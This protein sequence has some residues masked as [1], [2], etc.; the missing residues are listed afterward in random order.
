MSKHKASVSCELEELVFKPTDIAQ[1]DVDDNL[2]EL[3]AR[4]WQWRCR[5][6]IQRAIHYSWRFRNRLAAPH[7]LDQGVLEPSSELCDA[8]QELSGTQAIENR[9]RAL[10]SDHKSTT[11][12]LGHL[13]HTGISAPF[14]FPL[15]LQKHKH[16]YLHQNKHF[17]RIN[18][19]PST[20]EE[21][22]VHRHQRMA[23]VPYVLKAAAR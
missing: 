4:H 9:V 16:A 12:E 21:P 19:R 1:R 14:F 10:Q 11:G 5:S 15:A 18:F 2:L 13:Q 8:V 3:E 22:L 17:G 20:G 23:Q 7:W 6:S